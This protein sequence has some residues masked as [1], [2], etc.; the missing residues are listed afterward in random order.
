MCAACATGGANDGSVAFKASRAAGAPPAH[1]TV[2]RNH[3]S[4]TL[5]DAYLEGGCVRGTMGRL[6]LSLCDEGNGHWTG[7]SGDLTVSTRGKQVLAD[8]YLLLSAGRRV[9]LAGESIP[10]GEGQQW[11]ELRKAPVLAVIA[12]AAADLAGGNLEKYRGY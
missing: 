5:A 10:L 4:G 12:A 2:G 3:I 7:S 8:G 9:Q 6:P 1:Y 11:D